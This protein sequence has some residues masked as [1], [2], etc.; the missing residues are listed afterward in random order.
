[1]K[2]WKQTSS[3]ILCANT[4]CNLSLDGEEINSQVSNVWDATRKYFKV[5]NDQP[6]NQDHNLKSP[7]KPI[8]REE[9]QQLNFVYKSSQFSFCLPFDCMQW[10]RCFG[11][12][13]RKLTDLMPIYTVSAILEMN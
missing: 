8:S 6:T 4:F 1:M 10:L 9:I 5:G 3:V 12:L 7:F 11:K 13:L 2:A